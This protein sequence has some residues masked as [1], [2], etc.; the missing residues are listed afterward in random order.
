MGQEADKK[1]LQA[2]K[3]EVI[4]QQKQQRE[5]Q[6]KQSAKGHAGGSVTPKQHIQQPM[7]KSVM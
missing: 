6:G 3:A 2:T 7:A 1:A 5:Q 4:H